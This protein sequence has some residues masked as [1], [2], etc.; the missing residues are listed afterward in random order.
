[1]IAA[2]QSFWKSSLKS[3]RNFFWS[4]R[5]IWTE[6]SF[7]S[8]QWQLNISDSI[9]SINYENSNLIW[10][11]RIMLS[12][13]CK[14]SISSFVIKRNW[15]LFLTK[16]CF[17]IASRSWT[18]LLVSMFKFLTICQLKWNSTCSFLTRLKKI[19]SSLMSFS[20]WSDL[21][22]TFKVHKSWESIFLTRL[23]I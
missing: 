11:K 9:F 21:I 1:M 8:L 6:S 2:L 10:S 16:N 18:L 22:M 5:I 4:L 13:W 15:K 12:C 17:S 7:F 3:T 14:C 20:S 23:R 19:F